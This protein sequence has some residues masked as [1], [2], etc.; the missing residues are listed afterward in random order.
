MIIYERSLVYTHGVIFGL[1]VE[2][3]QSGGWND[4][5]CLHRRSKQ[6]YDRPCR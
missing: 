6:V 4:L 3:G 5:L 2:V 1:S